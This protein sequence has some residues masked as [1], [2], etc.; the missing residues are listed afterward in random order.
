VKPTTK[1]GNVGSIPAGCA[2]CEP[3]CIWAAVVQ[4]PEHRVYIV[5]V[6]AELCGETMK[7]RHGSY[8]RPSL[9]PDQ[10]DYVMANLVL[11]ISE[12]QH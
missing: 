6:T 11:C 5:I 3:R 1:L 4:R 9:C 2:K 10:H 8:A 12:L 7:G